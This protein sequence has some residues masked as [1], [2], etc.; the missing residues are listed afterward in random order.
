MGAMN[1]AGGIERFRN[2]VGVAVVILCVTWIHNWTIKAGVFLNFKCSRRQLNKPKFSV[3]QYLR[4]TNFRAPQKRPSTSQVLKLHEDLAIACHDAN[5]DATNCS[6][7]RM[8]NVPVQGEPPPS[9]NIVFFEAFCCAVHDPSQSKSRRAATWR[10]T[11]NIPQA[12]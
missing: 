3:R 7:S 10:G 6:A 5:V 11:A 2:W 12:P 8:R 1:T 4:R 9:F